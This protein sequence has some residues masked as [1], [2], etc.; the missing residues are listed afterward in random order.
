MTIDFRFTFDY[1]TSIDDV[2]NVVNTF[3]K[4]KINLWKQ[5]KPF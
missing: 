2:E 1:T 3:K 5:S 4:L